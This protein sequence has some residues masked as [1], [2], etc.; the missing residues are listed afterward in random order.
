VKTL[1]SCIPEEMHTELLHNQVTDFSTLAIDEI[2]DSQIVKEL[3]KALLLKSSNE[4]HR[5]DHAEIPLEVTWGNKDGFVLVAAPQ[6]MS[7]MNLDDL[8]MLRT[9]Y[10]AKFART[11]A[12]Q[13]REKSSVYNST[14][15]AGPLHDF[16]KV[17]DLIKNE[18]CKLCVVV[19]ADSDSSAQEKWTTDFVQSAT[20]CKKKILIAPLSSL[21]SKREKERGALYIL[22]VNGEN[23]HQFCF[24][25]PFGSP[26][27]FFGENNE[28]SNRLCGNFVEKVKSSG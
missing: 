2:S 27:D 11:L 19:L 28:L 10:V 5:V 16:N 17:K 13:I 6:L 22:N 25:D 21:T 9:C 23:T 1:Q 15:L 7:G 3:S 4:H 14:C 18:S 20:E 8:N 26:E 24:T 12:S